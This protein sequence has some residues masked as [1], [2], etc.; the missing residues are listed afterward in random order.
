MLAASK[1]ASIDITPHFLLSLNQMQS[2]RHLAHH[3]HH[4]KSM[5]ADFYGLM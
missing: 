3:H 4:G 1:Q 5:S 2:H